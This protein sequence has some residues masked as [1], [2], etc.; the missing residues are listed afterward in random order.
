MSEEFNPIIDDLNSPE[1]YRIRLYHC[2]VSK[3][4]FTSDDDKEFFQHLHNTHRAIIHKNSAKR[5]FISSNKWKKKKYM[6]NLTFF[7][8]LVIGSKKLDP[9]C[10][11]CVYCKEKFETPEMLLR[12]LEK[13]KGCKFQCAYC[14]FRASRPI[15]LVWHQ[16]IEW[17]A[18]YFHR[19]FHLLSF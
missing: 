13:Y 15:F 4:D 18:I 12:H 5:E 2:S 7:F 14:A 3:C 8:P 17:N 11:I 19:W 10:L 6:N 16:V 9:S 1:V